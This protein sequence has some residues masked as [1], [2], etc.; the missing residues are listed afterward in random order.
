MLPV[1]GAAG[2]G[3]VNVNATVASGSAISDTANVSATTTDP[4]NLN[5]SATAS[6]QVAGSADLSVTNSASPVPVVANT[7]ITYTQVVTNAGPSVAT[8]ASFSEVL[9]PNTTFF[10]L[11]PIPPGWACV[12][13]AT[14]SCTNP[15]FAPQ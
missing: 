10:S 1:G 12:F 9:P 15:S 5:N 2:A 6:V 14:I 13:G 7:N 11:S 4:N 8:N 3:V